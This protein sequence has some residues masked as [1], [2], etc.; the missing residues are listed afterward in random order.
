MS[1][2]VR[3]GKLLVVKYL[4]LEHNIDP[5]GTQMIEERTYHY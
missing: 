3:C 5:K 1:I 2:A 4:I